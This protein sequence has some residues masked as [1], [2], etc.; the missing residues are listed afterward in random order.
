MA[1]D[2]AVQDQPAEASEPIGSTGPAT[3]EPAAPVVQLTQVQAPLQDAAEVLTTADAEG[4]QPIVLIPTRATRIRIDLVLT[5]LALLAVALLVEISPPLRAAG[6]ALG[7]GLMVIGVFRAFFVAVPEGAQAVLVQR[8]KFVNRVGPGV[9][10]VRPGIVVSHVVTTRD[11]PFD[12]PAAAVAT[13]DDVRVSVDLLVTFR[14]IAPERFVFAISTSDFDQ[15]L[16]ATCQEAARVLVRS[17]PSTEILDVGDGDTDQLRDQIGVRLGRYGVEV[18]RVVLTHVVPPAQFVASHEAR[19]LAS[20]QRAEEEE[21]HAL[22]VLRESDREA[23]RRQEI[24]ARREELELEAE[25]QAG[26]MERLDSLLRRHPAAMRWDFEGE[27]L[28]VARA[29]AANSRA[30]LQVGTDSDV[31]GALL[32]QTRAHQELATGGEEETERG[33]VSDVGE[34]STVR[35]PSGRGANTQTLARASASR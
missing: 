2:A 8:G 32:M 17:K 22:Q 16:Q 25:N 24:R 6:G 31:A 5:G 29:L 10:F 4:R 18:V 1:S 3:P 28:G 14:I 33:T 26:R 35:K 23:L 13:S 12:A 27:R 19:R 30:L 15:V 9:Q 20:L 21:L 11:T 7:V 34:A